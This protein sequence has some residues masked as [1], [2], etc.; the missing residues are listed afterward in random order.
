MCMCRRISARIIETGI[1][2]KRSVTSGATAREV[3]GESTGISSA[4]RARTPAGQPPGRRRYA[5]KDV[6]R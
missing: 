3:R 1:S 2:R 4:R 5:L 6:Q